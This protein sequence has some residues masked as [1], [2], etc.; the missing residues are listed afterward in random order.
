MTDAV[1]P[2]EY[3][4]VPY[5]CGGQEQTHPAHLATMAAL[6]GL[7]PPPLATCRVLELGC[8]NGSNLIPMARALPQATF[9]GIDLSERQIRV[10]QSE[11]SALQ[12]QNLDLRHQNILDFGKAEQPFD[13]I[14]AHGVYSWVPDPVRKR[15]L[16]ICSRL[17][18][19]DGIAYLSYNTYPGWHLRNPIRDMMRFHTQ[20]IADSKRRVAQA[21]A[22]VN[23]VA[24]SI[25]SHLQVHRKN[26]ETELTRLRELPSDYLLHDDLA[27]I[28]QPFYFHEFV[29]DAAAHGLQFLAEAD[30]RAMQDS[31]LSAESRAMLRQ[32]DDLHIM[33]QYRDFIL[34]AAF[35]QTLLCHH[36]QPIDR[37]LHPALMEQ[38]LASSPLRC[39]SAT[40]NLT[41]SVEEEFETNA[42]T[43]SLSE[44]LVKAAVVIMKEHH[45]Q[46]LPFEVLFEAALV[47]S[48]TKQRAL[49]DP[50]YLQDQRRELGELLLAG[51]GAGVLKLQLF[52]PT[53]CLVPG[54]Y[55]QL[56]GFARLRIEANQE[57]TTPLL[58]NI[59]FDE[60]FGRQLALLCN[61]RRS[62]SELVT[63]MTERVARGELPKE[64]PEGPIPD[65]E[66]LR[67]MVAER[68]TECL[69]RIARYAL[70]VPNEKH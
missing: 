62:R 35:R 7:T 6:F 44:P 23:F 31:R 29:T 56:D 4:Q 42:I 40:P 41:E 8:G 26:V 52:Q 37:R 38:F 1:Q 18:S 57:A 55:P 48:Q 46:A 28:N 50:R 10:G 34:N 68:V 51:Y 47:R 60:P 36:D 12:I 43:L 5:P 13:Y 61:G 58:D 11:V 30:F 45:P 27:E 24:S 39:K 59:R 25:P 22:M 53:F 2:S 69:D 67:N 20:H 9:V 17:L 15:L 33:E 49:S 54:E 21:M 16:E 3:D 70:F 66:T 19:S 63:E 32:L 64:L 14:I 65:P